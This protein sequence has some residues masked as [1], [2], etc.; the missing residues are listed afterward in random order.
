[1]SNGGCYHTLLHVYPCPSYVAHKLF[2]VTWKLHTRRH[3]KHRVWPMAQRQHCLYEGQMEQFDKASRHPLS[4]HELRS[5][6]SLF[7][8]IWASVRIPYVGFSGR[9]VN[10][11]AYSTAASSFRHPWNKFLQDLTSLWTRNGCFNLCST[12]SCDGFF[13][14][15]FVIL[16]CKVSQWRGDHSSG[17][18]R[19]FP[20]NPWKKNILGLVSPLGCRPSSFICVAWNTKW[21]AGALEVQT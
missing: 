5:H 20:Y 17:I 4:L 16:T 15:V 11:H 19:H 6:R 10:A 14:F 8:S 21:P 18:S 12:A 3:V 7:P 1:M 9:A 2:W 13:L